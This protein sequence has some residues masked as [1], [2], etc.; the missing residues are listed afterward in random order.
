MTFCTVLCCGNHVQY[1]KVTGATGL[2]A[3]V[4]AALL[5]AVLAAAVLA[6][7][8]TAARLT[9]GAAEVVLAVLVVFFELHAAASRTDA[10]T[11]ALICSPLV[12]LTCSPLEMFGP[13]PGRRAR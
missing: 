10:V 8:V 1:C 2:A 6:A 12:T 13:N 7:A 4:T 9:A 3:A 11:T 5:T